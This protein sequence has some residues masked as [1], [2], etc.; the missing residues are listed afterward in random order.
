MRTTLALAAVL[1]LCACGDSLR[2]SCDDLCT[3][4]VACYDHCDPDLPQCAA[5][6]SGNLGQEGCS[7]ACVDGIQGFAKSCR[8]AAEAYN[9]CIA[10]LSCD[11][12][13]TSEGLDTCNKEEVEV[14]DRCQ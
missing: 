3:L 8:T 14:Q 10:Q 6:E 4:S 9:T 2:A 11:A 12:Y 13:Q 1:S 5:L 7:D